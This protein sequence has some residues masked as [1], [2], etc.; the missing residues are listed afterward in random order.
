MLSAQI[1]ATSL[2]VA[3]HAI[4]LPPLTLHSLNPS[5]PTLPVPTLDTFADTCPPPALRPQ[6]QQKTR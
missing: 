3:V 6:C 4:A 1:S 2:R 5:T